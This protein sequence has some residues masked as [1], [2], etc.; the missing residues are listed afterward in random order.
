M[1]ERT[2][3]RLVSSIATQLREGG[4]LEDREGGGFFLVDRWRVWDE[5]RD[6][7]FDVYTTRVA[8]VVRELGGFKRM[9]LLRSPD[10]RPSWH[11]EALYEFESDAILDRFHRDFA[12]RYRRMFPGQTVEDLLAELEPWVVGHEDSTMVWAAS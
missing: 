2:V 8:A 11:L 5:H 10:E 1:D 6:R 12:E 9:L 3:E 7:F 4:G